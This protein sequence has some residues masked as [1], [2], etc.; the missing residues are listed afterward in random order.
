MNFRRYNLKLG[1]LDKGIPKS[2]GVNVVSVLKNIPRWRTMFLVS[3]TIVDF[4]IITQ[5]SLVF[6][7][8]F[9]VLLNKLKGYRF[10]HSL[11]P[12]KWRNRQ[13]RKNAVIWVTTN[14]SYGYQQQF[15]CCSYP[16]HRVFFPPVDFSILKRTNFEK[17]CII[18]V[19]NV[20]I[21]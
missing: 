5:Y 2:T 7:V 14:S 10:P 19:W 11:I 12:L 3:F 8:I 17:T 18:S 1:C 16:Y 4:V 15:I 21:R 20:V 9:N 6:R 13:E